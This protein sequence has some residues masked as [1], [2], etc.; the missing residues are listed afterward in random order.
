ME[1]GRATVAYRTS[2]RTIARAIRTHDRIRLELR[3]QYVA[4]L[5]ALRDSR[6]AEQAILDFYIAHVNGLLNI[7]SGLVDLPVAPYNVARSLRGKEGV[8]L[9][10]E[11]H[12]KRIPYQGEYGRKHGR[13]METD[14]KLG[15]FLAGGWIAK[16]P[17]VAGSTPRADLDREAGR[18]SRAARRQGAPVHRHG[19]RRDDGGGAAIHGKHAIQTLSTGI[20]V[21]DGKER[22][23]TDDEAVVLIGQ[24][25]MDALMLKGA[26]EGV[27]AGAKAPPTAKTK[28]RPVEG[29]LTEYEQF[30]VDLREHVEAM[31]ELEEHNAASRWEPPSRWRQPRR[32]RRASSVPG[33]RRSSP[34]CSPRSARQASTTSPRRRRSCATPSPRARSSSARTR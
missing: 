8:H 28:T 18:P 2:T 30:V 20:V 6:Y 23:L 25:L 19:L 7:L 13:V 27:K 14:V 15:T 16:A 4:A 32:P 24:L 21:E 11:W 34:T 29:P 12:D 1:R 3:E 17:T 10:G 33:S 22:P 31:G 9:F 26:Y 5:E